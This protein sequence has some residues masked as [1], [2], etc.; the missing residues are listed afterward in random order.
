MSSKK[1]DGH[2]INFSQ[3]IHDLDGTPVLVDRKRDTETGMLTG[4]TI[5]T[6][7]I[8]CA[9]A[10]NTVFKTEAEMPTEQRAKWGALSVRIFDSA[11]PL[12]LK[13]GEVE[14]IKKVIG[15]FGWSPVWVYRALPLLDPAEA[16]E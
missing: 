12:A 10:L 2:K 11:E 1:E 13:T 14:R 7:G 16:T 4:G 3:V 9:R 5:L 15:L 8:M 6:L